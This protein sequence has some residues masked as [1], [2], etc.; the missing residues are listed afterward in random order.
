MT[1]WGEN[2]GM[3]KGKSFQ[4]KFSLS[5]PPTRY[6]NNVPLK[7]NPEPDTSDWVK[8]K[9]VLGDLSGLRE[10]FLCTPQQTIVN[11]LQWLFS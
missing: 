5:L 11:Q 2:G 10:K 3:A 4:H 7:K 8:F 6:L 1:F 9:Y